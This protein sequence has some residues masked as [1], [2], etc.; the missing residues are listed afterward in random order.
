MSGHRLTRRHLLSCA[1][2]AMAAPAFA[3]APAAQEPG[4]PKN[5]DEA[6]GR[7]KDGNERFANGKTRHAHESADWR[8]H[9]VGG[10][11]PF[12]TIL[13]CSDSRVPIELVFDQGL[14]DLFVIRVAGNVVAPDVVGSLAYAIE[15]LQTPLVIVLG[16]QN[17]GAVTAAIEAM[18]NPD[19][20]EIPSIRNLLNLIEPGLRGL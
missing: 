4:F 14:G 6:L 20:R 12:A 9:L 19:M 1:G 17:C 8:K 7:L 13:G 3:A 15:H 2:V 5:A 18:A 10:Q 16:H 11:K